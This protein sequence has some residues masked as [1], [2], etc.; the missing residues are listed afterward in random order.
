M[1]LRI[2]SWC[3]LTRL[4]ALRIIP[5]EGIYIRM[6]FVTLQLTKQREHTH[7]VLIAHIRF[8]QHLLRIYHAL[9]HIATTIYGKKYQLNIISSG[10]L[11]WSILV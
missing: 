3:T 7:L 6:D 4:Q 2:I 9:P 8:H 11:P 1:N 5:I 10:T